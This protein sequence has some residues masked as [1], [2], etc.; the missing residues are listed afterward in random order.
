[1][2]LMCPSVSLHP[3][4]YPTLTERSSLWHYHVILLSYTLWFQN[5][6]KN[7]IFKQEVSRAIKNTTNTLT[8]SVCLLASLYPPFCSTFVYRQVLMLTLSAYFFLPH[9]GCWLMVWLNA[10]IFPLRIKIC[11]KIDPKITHFFLDPNLY[12]ACQFST[13][14]NM[15]DSPILAPFIKAGWHCPPDKLLSGG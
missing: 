12:R 5:I 11:L 1:M 13:Q 9:C 14:Q 8:E 7:H 6:I 15:L 4:F 2:K 10:G 3:S